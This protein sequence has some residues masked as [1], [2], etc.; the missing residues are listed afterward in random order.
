[1]KY[2]P[3]KKQAIILYILEK[4]LSG[5]KSIS[6]V[7]SETFGISTNT[8][9]GY[10]NEL[11]KE[12]IISKAKRGEYEL[13]SKQSLFRFSRRKGEFQSDTHAFDV[14]LEDKIASYPEN[15][16]HI[17]LYA[18]SEMVNNVIDHSG[19]ENMNVCVIQNYLNTYVVIIDDGIGI[20]EK[21]K[22]HFSL[23]N[24]DE[25]ICEL[26]KG[27]LTTDEINHSGEG[28]FFTSKM[29]DSFMISSSGKIFTTSKYNNDN[30][31]DT[32]E[33]ASG[34][35]VFMSLSN[36]T[37]KNIKDIF[38]AYSNTDGAFTTTRIPLKNIFDSAPVSRSQAKRICNRLD[39][40][41]EVILDFQDV[42]W[43]GQGFAHQIFVVYQKANPTLSIKAENMNEN[44]ANMYNHVVNTV[45]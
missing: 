24:L 27:K 28:I 32:D 34:T 5:E 16:K 45:I 17:W 20:F 37:H 39:K 8:V 6:K 22:N 12:G 1:M 33:F 3:E 19:A 44:V 2:S 14:C 23:A 10:I 21:I 43:M 31:F 4:I 11:L 26:F 38:D 15:V 30:I 41:E 7:V 42:A 25:A 40:F 9:H 18:V 35:C 29:M 13:V 36:F